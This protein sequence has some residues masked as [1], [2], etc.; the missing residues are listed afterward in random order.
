MLNLCNAETSKLA[1]SIA[2]DAAR[3]IEDERA[4]SAAVILEVELPRVFAG[5]HCITLRSGSAVVIFRNDPKRLAAHPGPEHCRPRLASV[6]SS[7]KGE[8]FND[9][10]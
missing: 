10:Y 9:Q 5:G 8:C 3:I 4:Q 1:R 6:R 2:T 7:W